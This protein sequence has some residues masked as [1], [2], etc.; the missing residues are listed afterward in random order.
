MK[1][2]AISISPNTET[3]DIFLALKLLFSPWVF[4]RGD[5]TRRLEQWFRSYFNVSYA[6]AFNSGRSSLFAILKALNIGKG[7]EVILQAF[8]CVVVPNVVIAS[9]AMP[10]YTDINESLTMDIKDFE[11]KITKKTRAVIVQ[12][13]FGI[14]ADMT[15]I[16]KI[17]RKYKI[18]VIEDA[19]HTIGGTLEKDKLGTLGDAGFFSFGRDKAFSSVFGGIAITKDKQLGKRIREYQ[20]KLNNPSF[21][22]TL[23]QLLHPIAFAIILPLYDILYIGKIILVIAQKIKLLSIPVS[24]QEKKGKYSFLSA[25]KIPNSLACLALFQ[26]RR[27]KEFSMNREAISNIYINGL[28][29]K[30]ISVPYKENI[31]FLRFPIFFKRREELI[32]FLRQKGIYVGKWYSEIIDPKGVNFDRICYKKGSCPNAQ[33]Y[34]QKIIN[35]PTYPKMRI[36][37]ALLIKDLINKYVNDKRN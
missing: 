18:A 26:L 8:T 27:I 11:A 32:I 3:K 34:A 23:Q 16:K 1:T 20:K 17:A 9:G 37:D 7:D 28:S 33:Y 12:H 30:D 22:W 36:N 10:I 25:K 6:V 35:L 2:I 15:S 14:P 4:F 24:S 31:P 21:F 19:A 5:Y 13:T 29:S